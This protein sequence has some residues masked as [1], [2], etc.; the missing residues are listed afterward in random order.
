MKLA[1]HKVNI[2]IKK[3]NLEFHFTKKESETPKSS[4]ILSNLYLLPF[5]GKLAAMHMA[6][7]FNAMATLKWA[8]FRYR[9]NCD[10]ILSP[11]KGVKCDR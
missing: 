10:E 8:W 1:R 2:K 11:N 9:G 7:D 4:R 5:C 3:K 6:E